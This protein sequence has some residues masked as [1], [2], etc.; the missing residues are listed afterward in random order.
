MKTHYIGI[1]EEN[2]H[3]Y[4]D[5]NHETPPKKKEKR[6]K[7]KDGMQIIHMKTI[8]RQLNTTKDTLREHCVNLQ[9]T[10]SVWRMNSPC[11]NSEFPMENRFLGNIYINHQYK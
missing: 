8:L 9:W 6:I 1:K 3:K 11:M 5:W 2:K 4:A 10:L 7:K